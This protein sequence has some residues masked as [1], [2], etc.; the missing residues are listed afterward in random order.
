LLASAYSAAASA[1]NW[2]TVGAIAG[3]VIGALTL[4][5]GVAAFF[6]R[7]LFQLA[8]LAMGDGARMLRD[9]HGEEARPGVPSRPGVMERLQSL[10][11]TTRHRGEQVAALNARFDSVD[12]VLEHIGGELTVNGGGTVKDAVVEILANQRNGTTITAT[13]TT[14]QGPPQPGP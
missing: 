14:A 8:R 1:V 12:Q 4:I 2:G 11:D 3:T 13:V 7:P 5:G 6:A 9:W 10:D